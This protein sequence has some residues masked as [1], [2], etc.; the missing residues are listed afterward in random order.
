MDGRVAKFNP[1]DPG[2]FRISEGTH[3]TY[4]RII[5]LSFT[6][7]FQMV[8]LPV[9]VLALLHGSPAC[10]IDLCVLSGMPIVSPCHLI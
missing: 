6:K 4:E 2:P 10:D 1:D 9:L 5:A 7:G 3:R 8:V